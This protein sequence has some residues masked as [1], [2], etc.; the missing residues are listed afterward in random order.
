MAYLRVWD[1]TTPTGSEQANT[2]DDIIRDILEDIQE[3]MN[4]LTAGSTPGAG[5]GWTQDPVSLQLVKTN[6]EMHFGPEGWMPAKDDDD[7]KRA[8]EGMQAD[9]NVFTT[10]GGGVDPSGQY[11]MSLRIPV[12][13]D[14]QTI[15][16][17]TQL[18]GYSIEGTV[19]NA[20]DA[21]ELTLQ[22]ISRR[23]DTGIA[24]AIGSPIV[25]TTSGYAKTI[26]YDEAVHGSLIVSSTSIL[27]VRVRN[28]SAL[29]GRYMLSS[30]EVI[31]DI[32]GVQAMV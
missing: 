20:T 21:T 17:G 1:I 15:S 19:E 28:T 13:A 8:T 9:D 24:S 30:A 5:D 12:G 29:A 10:G 11:T 3:R 18:S 16:I 22:V 25:L 7:I 26:V 6:A 23:I 2:L 14:I 27:A 31:A 4:D 32:S